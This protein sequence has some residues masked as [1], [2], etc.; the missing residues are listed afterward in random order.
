MNNKNKK[1]TE[2]EQNVHTYVSKNGRNSTK[3][4]GGC[5]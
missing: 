2:N 1:R 5:L 4:S 3:K